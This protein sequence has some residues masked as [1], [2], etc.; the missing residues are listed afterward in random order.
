[1]FY[2]VTP[3]YSR[4]SLLFF[5]LCSWWKEVLISFV[6]SSDTIKSPKLPYSV[7]KDEAVV[8]FYSWILTRSVYIL[9]KKASFS[10]NKYNLGSLTR[11]V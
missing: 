4:I 5:F 8:A 6:V 10:R 2:A 11:L 7:L 3:E 9:S 1:M